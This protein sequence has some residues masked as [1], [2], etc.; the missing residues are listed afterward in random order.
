MRPAKSGFAPIS[1][2]WPPRGMRVP[3]LAVR[4][5]VLGILCVLAASAG[6]LADLKPPAKPR[7]APPMRFVRVTSADPQCDPNCPE[8]LSAE[9]KI[10]PGSAPAFAE[11]VNRLDGRRLPV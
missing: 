7:G 11:A 1:E 6:A 9:G 2:S 8:W 4:A 3:D 10:E 5:F